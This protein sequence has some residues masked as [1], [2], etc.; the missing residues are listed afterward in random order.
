MAGERV[1]VIHHGDAR[2]I[3]PALPEGPYHVITDPP[4]G[5]GLMSHGGR[6]R[7]GDRPMFRRRK[8]RLVEG[9]ANQDVGRAVIDLC[10]S[11]GWP[12]CV[13][14]SPEHPWPGDWRQHLVWN[15]GPAVGIGG[16]R[17]TCWKASWE[18]IQVGRAFPE[19]F[20]ERDEAV[21]HFPVNPANYADHPCA[22]PAN[23][24]RYLIRKLVPPGGI[25][26]DPFMGSGRTGLAALQVGREFVGIEIS[27]EYFHVAK[28]N[29]EH[30]EG[31]A[32][33][34]LFSLF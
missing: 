29:L 33:S 9:D 6:F 22:K 10:V 3:I 7:R 8:T 23:L 32:A 25:V 15:K 20:G 30:A 28:K 11:R 14:A 17:K 31:R 24:L 26:L 4:F 21:L 16:D 12:V 18:L 13:F 27:D 34:Q 19:V 2:Q 1:D 5:V